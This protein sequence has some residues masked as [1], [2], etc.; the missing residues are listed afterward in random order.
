MA[1]PLPAV[2]PC[3]QRRPGHHRH[4]SPDRV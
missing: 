4:T 2:W 1:E 3:H